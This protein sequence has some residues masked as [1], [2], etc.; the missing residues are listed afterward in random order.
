M[1][2][3]ESQ[4]RRM[5]KIEACLKAN[6]LESLDALIEAGAAHDKAHPG[7]YDAEVEKGQPGDVA[8]M[9]FTSGTTGNPKGVVHTHMALLDSSAAGARF[10]KLTD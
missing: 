9:F 7:L 8:A 3:F 1:A 10:D 5:P 2:K 6:G 4:E